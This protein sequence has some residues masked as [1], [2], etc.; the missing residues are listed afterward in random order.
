MSGAV[1]PAIKLPAARVLLA[2]LLAGGP[3]RRVDSQAPARK[4]EIPWPT[5]RR[6]ANQLGVVVVKDGTVGRGSVWWGRTS[7][8]TTAR[9]ATP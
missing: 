1:R 9:R 5:L 2:E 4:H 8:A 6:A 3:Q 7:S